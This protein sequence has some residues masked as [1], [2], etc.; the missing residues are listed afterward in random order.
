MG[1]RLIP[2]ET[3]FYATARVLKFITKRSK[4]SRGHSLDNVPVVRY[5][6]TRTL[7]SRGRVAMAYH[8]EE[9]LISVEFKP[10]LPSPRCESII[11]GMDCT[12]RD[13]GTYC[14]EHRKW[15]F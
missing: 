11:L 15:T 12:P 13:E 9:G 8:I 2:M 3:L 6:G 1:R 5:R 10:R 7:C 4:L 14:D